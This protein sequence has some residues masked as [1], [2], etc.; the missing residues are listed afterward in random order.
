[1]DVMTPGSLSISKLIRELEKDYINNISIIEFVSDNPVVAIYQTGSSFLVKGISDQV[2][3]YISSSIELE[4]KA[5]LKNIEA[6][7][8]HF[9]SIEDWLIPII[10]EGREIDWQMSAVRYYLPADIKIPQNQIP[11]SPLSSDDAEFIIANSNYKEFLT[12]DYIIDRISKSFSAG[13]YENGKLAAWGLTH[14]DGALGSL[15][16]VDEH[17]RKGY[18]TEITISL[19]RQCRE[20]GK[21]PYAQIVEENLP[22]INMVNN[23]GFVKDRRVTWL[24]LK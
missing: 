9:A 22:A 1:M 2:W 19:I 5:L 13:I 10:T 8:L 23:L 11:I 6:N 17:R 24:K 14:D 18:A 4:L 16:V 20:K 15:H 7:E 21:I 3:I 12:I